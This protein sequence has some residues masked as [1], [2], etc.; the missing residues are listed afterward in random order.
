MI[1]KM[2]TKGANWISMSDDPSGPA[3]LA[4]AN[5]GV[6]NKGY[7]SEGAAASGLRGVLRGGAYITG[8]AAKAMRGP[9]AGF[10]SLAASRPSIFFRGRLNPLKTDLATRGAWL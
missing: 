4:W 2:T 10:G 7:N 9:A 1:A 5:A 6:M 3:P 8:G